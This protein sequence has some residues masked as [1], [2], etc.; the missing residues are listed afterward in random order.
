MS[1]D[2]VESNDNND[3]NHNDDSSDSNNTHDA[4]SDEINQYPVLP[5]RDIIIF[6]EMAVPLFV[7]RHKSINA[8]EHAVEKDKKILLVTQ[9]DPTMDKP[10]A[11]D[12][13]H[14][15]VVS[16]ILQLLKLPDNTVKVLVE[17]VRK[18]KLLKLTEE[19]NMF[20]AITQNIDDF[21][22]SNKS[23]DHYSALIRTVI[24][25]FNKY[26]KLNLKISPELAMSVSQITDGAKLCDSIL[27]NMNI[28]I[29]E[30]QELLETL[31]VG[32]KLEKTLL[33]I[34]S[35]VT[36][37]ETEAVIQNNVKDQMDK[38]QREYYLN[39]QLKAI[40]KELGDATSNAQEMDK[41]EAKI[42]K[43][44]M[45]SEVEDKALAEFKKLKQMSQMSAEAGVVRNYIDWLVN[46][47]WKKTS[48]TNM[49][50]NK[51]EDILNKDHYSLDK[52]KERILEYI[53]VQVRTKKINGP[54]LCLVGPPGVGKTSLASSVAEATG[55][56]YVR[57]SLGGIHDE[58]EI[59]GHRRT[60][61]GSM[62]GRI[63]QSMK[64]CGT[65]NPL[66]LLDEI[67]KLGSSVHG[68]PASALLEVL[69]PE[70]NNRFSDHFLDVDY[71]LS[72][73]LFVAT[74]NSLDIPL[75]LLD[76]MEIIKLPGYTEEEKT[77][78]AKK[79]LVP[80]IVKEHGLKD[81]EFVINDDVITEIIR[82]YTREAGVRSLK[83]ELEKLARKSLKDIVTQ[84]DITN[85]SVDLNK[86]K[87]YC[88]IYKYNYGQIFKV[89]QIGV[90]NGLAYTTVGGEMLV[91][92]A[93]TSVGKGKMT[94]TGQLG[95]VMQ[96]SIHAA[97][98]YVRSQCLKFG[99]TPPDLNRRDIH[100]HLP[101][102][103]IPKDGPSAGVGMITTIV[104]VMTGIAVKRDLAMTGE[105]T[106]RGRVLA[107]GGL[108]EKLLAALRGGIKT[109]LIPE[110]NM[111]D[112]E[113]IPQ[114]V[115]D[116][117]EIIAV[118]EVTDV[119]NHA[120]VTQPEAVEWDE[121]AYFASLKNS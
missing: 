114:N 88:G 86:L 110:E 68:D 33:H 30:K 70:Q 47:P 84:N 40:H 18:V 37:L 55:R 13:Y 20:V 82:R 113:E 61:I 87:E 99:I 103:A 7:G 52:V 107:I 26:S 31:D 42:K 79:Y 60:Y 106:L 17:G 6:P 101:E 54:I 93:V 43:C 105:I 67:D 64:R 25:E 22:D 65:V 49:N 90:V 8:L 92:E 91:I 83:R 45:P 78:I 29:S 116:N 15:G 98:S 108:K 115:K 5:L 27:M 53:A 73:V 14:F 2:N 63:I 117:I 72:K 34:K 10:E 71:D 3:S 56:K 100:I 81:K 66:I 75:P 44:S 41:L 16:N 57:I 112:L 9:K 12:I 104:S 77:S 118:S 35:E 102:G 48:R 76:R 97:S 62:P 46:V 119:I 85:V 4:Q 24:E 50:L 38:M 111:K 58:S 36:L 59:R 21:Y 23:D 28:K 74:A 109:V 11:N 32:Q 80:K 96:E 19:E 69:D 39:E 1:E 121:E 95:D 94:L 120:L 89:D 51:A